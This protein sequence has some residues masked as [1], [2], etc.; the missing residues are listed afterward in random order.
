ME[1]FTEEIDKNYILQNSLDAVVGEMLFLLLKVKP[2]NPNIFM[3]KFLSSKVTAD[4]LADAGISL[5][6]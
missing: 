1:L 6:R 4:Y 5:S 3:I 2:K